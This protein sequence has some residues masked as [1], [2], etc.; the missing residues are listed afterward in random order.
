MFDFRHSHL[1]I[2]TS[3]S[4]IK[5]ERR[6]SERQKSFD[7]SAQLKATQLLLGIGKKPSAKQ[8]NRMLTRVDEE[9]TV[10]IRTEGDPSATF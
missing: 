10:D 3:Y 8:K 2:S 9:R 1:S 6:E 7:A 5:E 4:H